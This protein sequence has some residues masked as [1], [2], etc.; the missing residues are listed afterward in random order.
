VTFKVITYFRG[1]G[2]MDLPKI[3]CTIMRHLTFFS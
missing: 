3:N 2:A 1:I